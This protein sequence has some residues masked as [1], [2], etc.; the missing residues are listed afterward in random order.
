MD[1]T[2]RELREWLEALEP[3]ALSPRED[4][5]YAA[6]AFVAGQ[7]VSLD[8]D[9]VRAASRRAVFLLATQGDPRLALDLNDRAVHAVAR[10]LATEERQRE[11]LAGLSALR[12]EAMGLPGVM[13]TID[14]LLA[15][16]DLA[17][18]SLALAILADELGEDEPDD[19]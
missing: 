17:W 18:R 10:D 1:V 9:D 6:L 19:V 12:T 2:A 8:D 14:R 4:E 11:L 7:R 3:T 13:G 16:G 5:T 15:D